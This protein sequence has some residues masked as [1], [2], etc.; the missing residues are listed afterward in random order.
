M[1]LTLVNRA[2][3]LIDWQLAI[4]HLSITNAERSTRWRPDDPFG[5]VIGYHL[6][7]Q[8]AVLTLVND[9]RTAVRL[10]RS[11]IKSPEAFAVE[12]SPPIGLRHNRALIVHVQESCGTWMS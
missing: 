1:S 6:A 7:R 10:V 4:L 8:L 5:V 12:L 3:P 2:S 11:E 9:P